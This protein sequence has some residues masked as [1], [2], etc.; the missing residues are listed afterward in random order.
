MRAEMVVMQ[1][2][3]LAIVEYHIAHIPTE[4]P[5]IPGLLSFRE[6]SALLAVWKK[7]AT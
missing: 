7:T 2:P 4:F 3:S 5:Y 1:W 6:Y